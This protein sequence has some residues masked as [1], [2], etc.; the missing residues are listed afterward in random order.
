MWSIHGKNFHG[1]SWNFNSCCFGFKPSHTGGCVPVFVL[2]NF[3]AL[4]LCFFVMDG[5]EPCDDAE[6]WILELLRYNR[7]A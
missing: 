5:D 1:L 7:E 3:L 2:A 4:G 6:D